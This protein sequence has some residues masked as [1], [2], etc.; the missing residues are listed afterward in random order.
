MSDCG[1]TRIGWYG[2]PRRSS[3]SD[4]SI[5]VSDAERTDISDLLSKHY[6]DG[7]LD[8]AEFKMRLDRAMAAKT[9][10]DLN[11]LL[12]DLPPLESEA[13]TRK[14]R[15]GRRAIWFMT[16]IAIVVLTVGFASAIV[17]PHIPW[18][19]VLVVFLLLWHRRSGRFSHHHHHSPGY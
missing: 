1:Y 9:R 14:P 7:R 18:I 19:L 2:G 10:A 4:P 17:P 8:D 13:R 5:R 15:I 6:A 16:M 11:G 3:T 12:S